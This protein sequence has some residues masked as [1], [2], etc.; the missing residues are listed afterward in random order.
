MKVAK[1]RHQVELGFQIVV[2]RRRETGRHAATEQG[3]QQLRLADGYGMGIMT[4]L[5]A[6][7]LIMYKFKSIAK[8]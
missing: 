8:G 3:Q 2:G 5:L 1:Q 7:D 6:V 4:A